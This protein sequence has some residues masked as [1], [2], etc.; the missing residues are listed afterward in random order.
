MKQEK[1]V[2]R[3]VVLGTRKS[4]PGSTERQ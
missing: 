3:L 1:M 2:G 4:N